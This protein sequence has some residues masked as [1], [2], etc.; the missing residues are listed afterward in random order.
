[1]KEIAEAITKNLS[2]AIEVIAA[3]VIGIALI[4][5]LY[6][7]VRHLF[8]PNDQITNQTIRIHFGS[9]SQQLLWNFCLLPIYL[10]RQLLPP[11]TILGNSLP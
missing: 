7:Y 10:L 5:F 8:K 9:L 3:S 6:K 2:S 4:Q 1:M 11:G